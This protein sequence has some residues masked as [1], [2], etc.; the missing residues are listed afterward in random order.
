MQLLSDSVDSDNTM[1]NDQQAASQS[2]TPPTPP[3]MTPMRSKAPSSSNHTLLYAVVGII[4]IV[5]I[6]AVFLTIGHGNQKGSNSSNSSS[7]NNSTASNSS[8]SNRSSS[9]SSTKPSSGTTS[10]NSTILANANSAYCVGGIQILNYPPGPT[11]LSYYTNISKNSISSWSQTTSYPTIVGNFSKNDSYQSCTPYNGYVY[12]I[13]GTAPEI[14]NN[15]YFAQLSSQG[16]GKW[17]ATTSYPYTIDQEYCGAYSGYIYCVGGNNRTTVRSNVTN[18]AS[19][20]KSG[21]GTWHQ[22]SIYPA[23]SIPWVCVFEGS[24]VYCTTG[25][26]YYGSESKSYYANLTANGVG[27]WIQ[28]TSFPDSFVPGSC[29]AYNGYIYLCWRNV[30]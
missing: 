26:N 11:S 28:T 21:I 2:A 9:N 7:V 24:Y 3:S 18:Y 20:S 16:I 25:E 30:P 27:T 4:I 13:G 8:N 1:L 23:D 29:A 22:S 14:V 17:N 5:V 6:A 15:S 10:K 12:C 19:I